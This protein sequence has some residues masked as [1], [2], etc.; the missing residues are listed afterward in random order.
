MIDGRD[1]CIL[2]GVEILELCHSALCT[3]EFSESHVEAFLLFIER[4]SR[5]AAISKI[6]P[7][8]EVEKEPAKDQEDVEEDEIDPISISALSGGG[9][10]LSIN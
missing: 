8:I 9:N 7:R 10:H 4:L 2:A 3:L 5:K 6:G 1:K